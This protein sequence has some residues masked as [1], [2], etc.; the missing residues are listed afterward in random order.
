[1]QKPHR[2]LVDSEVFGEPAVSTINHEL[3]SSGVTGEAETSGSTLLSGIAVWSSGDREA[4][5]DT[6]VN[7]RLLVTS[8]SCPAGLVGGDCL[9]SVWFQS[10]ARPTGG[11]QLRL[12]E[13]A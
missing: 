1:M 11:I 10:F 13:L 7:S 5:V 2:T 4:A 9:G 8:T 12:V 6:S 3:L